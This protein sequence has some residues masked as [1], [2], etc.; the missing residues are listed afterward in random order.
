GT[1]H[2]MG[3]YDGI[4][5][6][7]NHIAA[8]G[9]ITAALTMVKQSNSK[10]LP[11]EV[12]IDRLDQLEEALAAGPDIILLDNFSLDDVAQAVHIT[13]NR[14]QLEVSGGVSSEQIS[15]LAS[16]GVHRISM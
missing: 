13:N 4:L 9:S 10:N 14:A 7:D 15:A 16:T 8:A 12:E 6:K 5:I 2:R 1:N 11:V 3:L